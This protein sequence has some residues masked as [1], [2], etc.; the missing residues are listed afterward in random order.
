MYGRTERSE[1]T[2]RAERTVRRASSNLSVNGV[3]EVNNSSAQNTDCSLTTDDEDSDN[4]TT[5]SYKERRRE[6]HTFAEQKRRDAIK[7]GYEELQ[8]LV[9]TCAQQDSLS[10][11]KL[12][13]A[14][15]LQKSIDYIQFLQQQKKKQEEELQVLRKEVV[16]LQIMKSN[17]EQMVKLHQQTQPGLNCNQVSDEVKLSVFQALC[18]SL[19]ISFDSSFDVTN[20]QELSSRVFAWLE[21]HCNSRNMKDHAIAILSQLKR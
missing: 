1:K 3:L 2:E 10:S 20:F 14:T 21:E 11:Y 12:S 19:F 8:H 4:K 17:Y 5:I 15:V 6:A 7:R 16:A 9:P 18:D 13:K